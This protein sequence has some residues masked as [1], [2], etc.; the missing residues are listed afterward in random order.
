M[1]CD[2][3]QRKKSTLWGRIKPLVWNLWAGWM[4]WFDIDA[5]EIPESWRGRER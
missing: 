2:F 4:A 1:S 3:I 5:G